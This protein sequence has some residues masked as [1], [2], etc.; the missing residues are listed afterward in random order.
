MIWPWLDNSLTARLSY[1]LPM[2]RK[3]IRQETVVVISPSQKQLLAEILGNIGVAW[4]TAGV[5]APV[6][7][8]ALSFKLLFSAGFGILFTGAFIGLALYIIDI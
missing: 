3:F 4:F 6:F 2:P 7:L 1:L 8:G 5:I